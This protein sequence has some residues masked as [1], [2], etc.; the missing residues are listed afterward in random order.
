MNNAQIQT[1]RVISVSPEETTEYKLVV[2]DND[3]DS[4]FD[5]DFVTVTVQ[6]SPNANAGPDQLICEGESITLE[7]SGGGQYEWST[8]ET[9]SSITVNPT[10]TTT[11]TLTTTNGFG[12]TD[13]DSVVVTVNPIAPAVASED[14]IIC[15]GESVVLEVEDA[16]TGVSYLWS[17]GATE[18]SITV[19]PS[20]TTE[21]TVTV[22]TEDGCESSDSVEVK[23]ND[24]PEVTAINTN[25]TCE[26]TSDGSIT[27][28]FQTMQTE[29]PL[30]SVLMV[31]LLFK[32]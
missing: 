17:T 19:S 10:T 22:I 6:A 29:L 13:T 18:T 14:K 4:C 15:L 21:Y 31:V 28:S 32:E 16:G 27:F 7:G 12:C 26:D 20:E 11:Y 24:L 8:G 30:P 23:V 5:T 3:N 1:G 9:T 25:G 2:S